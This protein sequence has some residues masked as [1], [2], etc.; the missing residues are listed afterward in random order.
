MIHAHPSKQA[1]TH[2]HTHQVAPVACSVAPGQP[3]APAA[4]RAS[5]QTHCVTHTAPAARHATAAHQRGCQ[6]AV[7]GRNCAPPAQLPLRTHHK[8]TPCPARARAAQTWW[9][10]RGPC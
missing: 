4:A 6:H 9:R 7:H 5:S 8:L 10:L 1:A 2:I 3:A